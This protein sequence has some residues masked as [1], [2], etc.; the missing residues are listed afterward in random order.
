MSALVLKSGHAH[1][2]PE[3]PRLC[4]TAEVECGELDVS[5]AQLLGGRVQR[6][7]ED[8]DTVVLEHVQQRRLARVVEAEE[9]QFGMLVREPELGENVPDCVR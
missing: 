8:G 1:I 7:L 6:R 3:P 2:S 4:V 5:N 9:E